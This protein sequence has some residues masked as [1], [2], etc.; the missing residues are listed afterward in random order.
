M[1]REA[2]RITDVTKRYGSVLAV[3]RLSFDVPSGALA[4]L[5]GPN[6]AG[7][8]T[9]MRMLAGTQTPDAGAIIVDGADVTATPEIARAR[10]GIT[11]QELD[12]LDYLTP[13]ETLDVVGKLRG[14]A[15][16]VRQAWAERWLEITELTAAQGKLTRE[17]S[18]GMKRKLAIGAALIAEPPVVLLD[19]SFTGLD[20]ESTNAIQGE[21][22]AYCDRGGTVLLSSHILDMVFSLADVIVF[23]RRGRCVDTLTREEVRARIPSEYKDLTAMYLELTRS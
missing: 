15:D 20:P 8:S 17:L 12:M 23:M 13:I 6:G 21:L 3:D 4:C 22:R 1:S 2:I 9:A 10:V 5:V 16:D 14:V 18:G 11:P 7:K 19:E